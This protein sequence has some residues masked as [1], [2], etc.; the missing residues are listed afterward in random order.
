MKDTGQKKRV[1]K[2]PDRESRGRV[3]SSA[4]G[5][6][7]ALR[8]RLEGDTSEGFTPRL[9][10]ARVLLERTAMVRGGRSKNEPREGSECAPVVLRGL[11]GVSRREAE[12]PTYTLAGEPMT[13]RPTMNR[14]GKPRSVWSALLTMD[15]DAHARAVQAVHPGTSRK[16]A[17]LFLLDSLLDAATETARFETRDDGAHE[18]WIDALGRVRVLVWR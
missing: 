18:V 1:A 5:G 16:E 13:E 2:Q 11:Q 6:A 3:L 17:E 8:R 15:R 9:P 10:S 12:G 14:Q 7:R 4:A